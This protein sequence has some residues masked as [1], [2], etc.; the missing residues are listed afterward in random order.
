MQRPEVLQNSGGDPHARRAQDRAHEQVDVEELGRVYERADAEPE[1]GGHHDADDR[2]QRGHPAHAEHLPDARLQAHLEEQ[3]HDADLGQ[4]GK[5]RVFPKEVERS[6]PEEVKVSEDDSGEELPENRG[7]AHASEEFTPELGRDQDDGQAEEDVGNH[8]GR[9]AAR[10]GQR[11][12]AIN[13]EKG[14]GARECRPD[15][16]GGSGRHPDRRPVMPA[17][18]SVPDGIRRCFSVFSH[19]ECVPM[20]RISPIPAGRWPGEPALPWS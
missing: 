14:D 3:K 20:R 16:A 2:H 1:R 10:G 5:C 18:M 9:S 8:L 7:L 12:R 13:E 15:P 17:G 6:D 4:N 19:R 11:N